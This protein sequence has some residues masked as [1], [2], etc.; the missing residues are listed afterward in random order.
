MVCESY[1]YDSNSDNVL[2]H[3]TLRQLHRMRWLKPYEDIKFEHRDP[4][5][6]KVDHIC[7]RTW[8]NASSTF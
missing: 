7:S 2:N 3:K 1:Y 6:Y 5:K 8:F 4:R